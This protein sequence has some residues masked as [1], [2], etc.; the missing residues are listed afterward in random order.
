MKTVFCTILSGYFALVNV[1]C[2]GIQSALDPAGV[3]AKQ[4]GGHWWLMFYTLSAVFIIVMIVLL[5][6]ISRRRMPPAGVDATVPDVIPDAGR[7]YRMSRVVIG[8]IGITIVIL[9]VLLISS[10]RTGKALYYGASLDN[11][12]LIVEVTGHQWWW[13]VKYDNGIASQILTTA[14]LIHIPAGRSVLLKLKA[15]DVIHSFWVPNLHGKTDLIPGHTNTTW[16]WADRVG[17]YRGQCAEFCGYQ[18]A[19][20]AFTVIVEPADSFNSWYS[21]QILPS[22]QPS[23]DSQ[24]KGQKVFLT[25]T[26]IM[27]HKIQG[28]DAGG[29]VGPDLTHIGSRP[30]IAAGTLENNRGNL[31]GWIT[32]SQKIKPGNRMPPNPMDPADLQALLDYLQSLK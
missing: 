6:A 17:V 18:H 11:G 20:M 26:C 13:E 1:G 22:A 19:H 31:A 4:I 27:C 24:A 32:D 10:F 5:V 8:G 12:P 21:S 7:E 15:D 28:T 30:T 23:T 25:S 14:N 29:A 3:Q 2:P 9:F 16:I